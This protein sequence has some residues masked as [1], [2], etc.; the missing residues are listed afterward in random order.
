MAM[1]HHREWEQ[2]RNENAAHVSRPVLSCLTFQ[3]IH[4]L[5]GKQQDGRARPAPAQPTPQHGAAQHISVPGRSSR[6]HRIRRTP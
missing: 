4:S 2:R 1:N 6:R 3:L 5:A